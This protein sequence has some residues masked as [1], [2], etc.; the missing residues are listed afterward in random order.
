MVTSADIESNKRVSFAYPVYFPGVNVRSEEVT[1]EPVELLELPTTQDEWN[2]HTYYR[3]LQG[4]LYNEKL[5]VPASNVTIWIDPLDATRE[6]TE[7]LYQY[8]TNMIGVAVNGRP[9]IGI[10]NAPFQ[11]R[12]KLGLQFDSISLN[13]DIGEGEVES[14]E[15]NVYVSRSYWLRLS[16]GGRRALQDTFVQDIIPAGGAGYKAWRVIEETNSAYIHT[17][18]IKLWDLCAPEAVLLASG[19]RLTQF[20]GSAIHYGPHESALHTGGKKENVN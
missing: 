13:L 4:T 6:Y 18:R 8:V 5:I 10:L 19:G 15:K 3:Q 11:N 14:S 9:V 7:G 2:N 12:T 20:D 17:R 1:D 16:G